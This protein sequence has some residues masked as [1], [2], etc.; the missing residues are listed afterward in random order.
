MLLL[1]VWLG[2]S[3][4][5][6][7]T[8]WVRRNR[9]TCVTLASHQLSFTHLFPPVALRGSDSASRA[10]TW[11]IV[12]VAKWLDDDVPSLDSVIPLSLLP[13][14]SSQVNPWWWWIISSDF[15]P[16]EPM[17]TACTQ[18]TP[19]KCRHCEQLNWAVL[20]LR[21]RPFCVHVSC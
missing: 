12:A 17:R 3:F 14:K 15:F 7:S 13:K 6:Y 21:S 11:K 9:C 18:I 8:E 20:T 4:W 19:R 2:K 16:P 10:E 5:V 1:N